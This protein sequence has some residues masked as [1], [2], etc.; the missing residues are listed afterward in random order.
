MPSR[1]SSPAWFKR[2]VSKERR[3][4]F[5]INRRVRVYRIKIGGLSRDLIRRRLAIIRLER[6]IGE[7]APRKE[8]LKEQLARARSDCRGLETKIKNLSTLIQKLSGR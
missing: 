1:R 3:E 4:T 7:H 6:E 8:L 2:K 5:D